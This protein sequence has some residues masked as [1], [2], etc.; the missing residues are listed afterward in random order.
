MR[1]RIFI[2]FFG[3]PWYS[4]REFCKS[5][6]RSLIEAK[7]V[8]LTDWEMADEIIFLDFKPRDAL[9]RIRLR[10]K[11]CKLFIFEPVSVNPIQYLPIVRRLFGEIVEFSR[12]PFHETSKLLPYFGDSR[13]NEPHSE[14][15]NVIPPGVVAVAA[16]DKI[17]LSSFSRYP[18]RRLAIRH[19]VENGVPV[20]LAGP[21]W[22]RPAAF[23]IK[24]AVYGLLSQ[25]LTPWRIRFAPFYL[26]RFREWVGVGGDALTMVGEVAS[27]ATFYLN[28]G[29]VL[30]IENDQFAHS[31]KVYTA[32]ASMR[33]VVYVG[34]YLPAE[35]ESLQSV[36]RAGPDPKD[37]LDKCRSALLLDSFDEVERLSILESN[38][39]DRFE[40]LVAEQ[41]ASE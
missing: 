1:R 2:Q 17:S 3:T 4:S 6:L 7:G 19:L 18:L 15:L 8:E 16:A 13:A 21:N 35:I 40:N 14:F 41:I 37:I 31:E 28:S 20:A 5:R 34:N 38:S 12:T 23:R 10:G 26:L 30:V 22:E 11:T 29:A 33:P 32:L 27:V 9:F 39:Y 36:F 24:Q 25:C